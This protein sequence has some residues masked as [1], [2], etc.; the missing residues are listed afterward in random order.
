MMKPTARGRLFFGV[1]LLVLAASGEA[2]FTAAPAPAVFKS[3]AYRITTTNVNAVRHGGQQDQQDPELSVFDAGETAVSWEDYK[4]QKP[5]EFKL[6]AVD[7][8]QCWK[9]D[10]CPVEDEKKF[11]KAWEIHSAERNPTMETHFD[12]EGEWEE[13]SKGAWSKKWHEDVGEDDL[14]E[15]TVSPAAKDGYGI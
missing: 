11:T 7:E 15:D 4:K 10:E 8:M 2:F 12:S 14:H 1:V 5:D 9:T 6:D 3:R 13:E